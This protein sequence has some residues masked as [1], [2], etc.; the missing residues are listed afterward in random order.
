MITFSSKVPQSTTGYV[1]RL[2]VVAAGLGGVAIALYRAPDWLQHWN[3]GVTIAAVIGAATL[4]ILAI[5]VAVRG[6]A[7][8]VKRV[9]A[10]IFFLACSLVVAEGVLL[11]RSP[12]TWSDNPRAQRAISNARGAHRQGIEH[13]SRLRAEV[14]RALR[15]QG[16][17]TV[18][19]FS[20]EMSADARAVAEVRKRGLLSLGNVSNTN[21]VECNEGTGYLQFR[22][23]EFGFNN[24]PGRAHGPV[25]VAVIGESLALG[26]C[27]A[28]AKS[29]VA[30][31]RSRYPRTGNFGIPGS[32]VL[33]QLG[34]FREYVEPLEPSLVIWF[35][36]VGYAE[37]M[38]ES[39]QLLLTSYLDPSF[40][41]NLRERQG[42]V[43]SFI[44]E[45]F[46]P[47]SLQRDEA[48]RTEID[49]ASRLPL[50]RLIRLREV[51]RLVAPQTRS[52]PTA[53]DLSHFRRAVT[54][55]ADSA[56]QWGGSLLV[57]ILPS[58][59]ISTGQ[60]N[61]VL[62]YR[63][64]LDVLAASDVSIVDGVAL[65]EAEP[66]PLGLYALRS[67]NHPNEQGHA[68]LADAVISAIQREGIL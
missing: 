25:D 18:P 1:H 67:D 39:N 66:D 13:D 46:V 32:R 11:A 34:V 58:Y 28:P 44:R 10:E 35:V 57:V 48:L 2:F 56:R 3:I 38:H 50:D 17:D 9:A 47:L 27:V 41:Q 21:V 40:S 68:L 14:V 6:S 7:H 15:S 45:F 54:L 12:E 62:R 22:S 63:T 59:A 30:L 31:V 49:R 52:L 64:V 8:A 37:A 33:S 26:H 42:E 43:D 36:N 19:G 29:A 24:P 61:S 23:D 53:P 4:L 16:Q 51:R 60:P 55:V 20:Q 5:G 65:F